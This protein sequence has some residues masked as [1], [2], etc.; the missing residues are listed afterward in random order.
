MLRRIPGSRSRSRGSR[1]DGGLGVDDR[2][3][4]AG[5]GA[6]SRRG[7]ARC[8]Q[9]VGASGRGGRARDRGAARVARRRRG[10]RSRWLCRSTTATGRRRGRSP[11]ATGIRARCTGGGRAGRR[12]GPCRSPDS[13]DDPYF[14][15]GALRRRARRRGRG[16]AVR[17]PRER[18][19]RGTATNEELPGTAREPPNP[20]LRIPVARRSGRTRRRR[21]GPVG[22]IIPVV[23]VPSA[24]VGIRAMPPLT[25]SDEALSPTMTRA[26]SESPVRAEVTRHSAAGDGG[27]GP[28]R[29][30]PVP[31]GADPSRTILPGLSPGSGRHH[32]P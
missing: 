25:A 16:A 15:A 29:D 10:S 21:R 27:A 6:V 19:N 18:V 13:S 23:G 31:A 12:R 5:R 30:R 28:G 1:P 17:I 9:S 20:A 8:R 4:C 32:G 3:G 26:G 24:P 14:V 11:S 22:F 2:G 7:R